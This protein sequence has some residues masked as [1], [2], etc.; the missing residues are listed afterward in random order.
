[1]VVDNLIELLDGRLPLINEIEEPLLFER[2]NLQH[3]GANVDS[4]IW[5][6]RTV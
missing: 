3:V 5:V 6:N 1:M 2:Q 4:Y